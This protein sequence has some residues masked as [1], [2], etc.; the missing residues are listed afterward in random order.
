VYE[1][2]Q[3]A[4]TISMMKGG[5][6]KVSR[7]QFTSTILPKVAY[8]LLNVLL[9]F[10]PVL[11]RYDLESMANRAAWVGLGN[12]AILMMLATRNSIVP[13]LTGWTFETSL[14]AHVW[15]G[16][17]VCASFLL[18]GL[19]HLINSRGISARDA[20]GIVAW[21]S[22][23]I[24]LVTSLPIVRHRYFRVFYWSHFSFL[25]LTV[26]GSMHD[27][28]VLWYLMGGLVLWLVDRAIRLKKT[29]KKEVLSS[30]VFANA[31]KLELDIPNDVAKYIFVDNHPYSVMDKSII[32]KA[33][34]DWSQKMVDT[35]ADKVLVDGL[36]G[37][38]TLR[39]SM[40]ETVLLISGGVGFTAMYA[41]ARD[42]STRLSQGVSYATTRLFVVH[43][44][45]LEDFPMFAQEVDSLLQ[46]GNL[47]LLVQLTD[48]KESPME[49][50]H[51]RAGKLS[52]NEILG[53]LLL[54]T[55]GTVGVAVCGPVSLMQDVVS[56][57]KSRAKESNRIIHVGVESFEW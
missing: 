26:F 32:I 54:R 28:N 3:D 49:S 21:I 41:I 37:V 46:L 56:T 5:K 38:P 14:I 50:K 47:T 22:V 12:V 11:P 10:L 30:T 17:T 36:Y 43:Y 16:W 52:V 4:A 7:Y 55:E 39:F 33:S 29:S 19:L 20:Y 34:G 23:W 44:C 25:I 40:Y 1:R 24:I 57:A 35:P 42:I 51:I 9:L 13:W 18:H 48:A 15:C 8:V 45:R 6:A 2:V 27:I 31:I 53:G